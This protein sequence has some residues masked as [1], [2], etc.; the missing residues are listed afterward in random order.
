MGQ[1]LDAIIYQ[2]RERLSISR[3]RNLRNLTE[4]HMRYKVPGIL[5]EHEVSNR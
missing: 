3:C 5:L 2:R 1:V 4:R